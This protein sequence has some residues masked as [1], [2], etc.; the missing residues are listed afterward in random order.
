MT[1]EILLLNKRAIVIGADS[2]VT[3]SSGAQHPRYSK[4]ANKIFELTKHGSMAAAV[5]GSANLDGVPW[6]LAIKLFRSHLGSTTF[7]QASD[8]AT[9]LIDFLTAND[10]LFPEAFR[11]RRT[12]EQ[13][14]SAVNE[15][16][17]LA[18]NGD[19]SIF[20][21]G[22]PLDERRTAWNRQAERIRERLAVKGVSAPLSA[23]SLQRLLDDLQPWTQRV[24]NQFAGFEPLS[25][26]DVED[27]AELAHRLRYAAPQALLPCSGFVVA[28]YGDDQIFPA[29]TQLEIFGH[30][31]SEL[32][33]QFKT[34]YEVTL[35]DGAMIQPLAISSMIN[36]FTD[37]FDRSLE[38][39]VDEQSRVAFEKV[40]EKLRTAGIE[41]PHTCV[42]EISDSCQHDFMS[43]WKRLNRLVNRSPL[44]GVLQSLGVEEMA[45][46][47]AS[48]LQHQ[49]LKERVTSSSETVSG[50]I[51]VAA[52]TKE[53]GL[54]WIHR[55]HFFD[56][57]LNMRYA[58]RLHH[59]LT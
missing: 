13:F 3:T 38:N 16:A 18:R 49:S 45:H 27:V 32:F 48:L 37:G 7:G 53:E 34:S 44:L 24:L 56:L 4:S 46:L 59:S 40:F 43:E 8:Y 26:M 33:H 5:Y 28:G 23:D 9:A 36:A 29:Y 51:D 20:D 58:A 15:I 12:T 11:D 10:R 39:I 31:G 14:D 25:A 50:P 41:V 22:L 54:V 42:D 6:E 21:V 57:N 30:V 47:A 19:L 17:R 2:A 1:S 55:K 52:I 35:D